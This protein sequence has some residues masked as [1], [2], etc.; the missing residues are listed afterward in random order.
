MRVLFTA[1]IVTAMIACTP[2]AAPQTVA[3][4]GIAIAQEVLAAER[5]QVETAQ[6]LGDRAAIRAT[7]ADDAWLFD[8]HP[9][10]AREVMQGSDDAAS[11]YTRRQ[12]HRV[13]VSCDG[14]LV[15]TTGAAQVGDVDL[16][17]YTTIWARQA[18]GGWRWVADQGG[19]LAESLTAPATP[20]V[21]I[22]E[23]PGAEGP[24]AQGAPAPGEARG[25]SRDHTLLWDWVNAGR[26]RGL[27]VTM[28][29]GPRYAPTI[30]PAPPR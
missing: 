20:A 5:A 14:S 16:G 24:D 2:V 23:C 15:A 12:A 10:R 18:D 17:W 29:I 21:E 9:V 13:I 25:G 3:P 7:M 28:W 1:M 30:N 6:R 26:T 27:R 22:A 8:S 19:I 4:D 11:E